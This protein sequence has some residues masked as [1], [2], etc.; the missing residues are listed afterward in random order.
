MALTI[1]QQPSGS[2]MA[3]TR[4]PYVISGS[5]NNTQPQFRYV[6]DVYLSGS[7]NLITRVT[8]PLNPAGVAVFDPSRIFQ[9]SINYDNNWYTTSSIHLN[10]SLYTFNVQFGEQYGTSPSSSVSITTNIASD[11]ILVVPG[12]VDPNNGVSFD[13]NPSSSLGAG[14]ILTNHPQSKYSSPFQ[15]IGPDTTITLNNNDYHTVTFW[16][17]VSDVTLSLYSTS[18]LITS[19]VINGTGERFQTFGIG[20]KNLINLNSASFSPWFSNPNAAYVKVSPSPAFQAGAANIY[21]YNIKGGTY[22]KICDNEYVRFA[23]INEY[24]FYDYYNVYNPIRKITDLERES[25]DLPQLSYSDATAPYNILERGQTDYYTDRQDRYILTT[26]YLT[27]ET[28]DWLLELFES[29]N[30]F[31]QETGL[32]YDASHGGNIEE[33]ITPYTKFI[34]IVVT[35]TNVVT[36]DSTAR[37]KTFQYVIEFKFANK[38]AGAASNP[39]GQ[40][41]RGISPFNPNV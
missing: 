41:D 20:P 32:E 34:P 18:S 33:D 24:G 26:E 5:T 30:V 2:N 7:S 11:N 31:V 6:M 19:A 21:D 40:E 15:T 8:Q 1:V 37:N 38:R 27:K 29:P 17:G 13:F 35:N 12:T 14:G 23:F 22:D 4:L 25:V 28:A 36:N 39:L 10:P 9:D 16:Q 3:Y